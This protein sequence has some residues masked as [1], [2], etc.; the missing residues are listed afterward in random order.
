MAMTRRF[1]AGLGGAAVL[2]GVVTMTAVAADEAPR[3]RPGRRVERI[4]IAGGFGQL[5]VALEDVGADDVA[6]L[7]LAGERGARVT[8]V[9]EG[10]AAEKA[11]IKDDDV[12]LQFGGDEV[13]SAAQLARLVRETP[14]GRKV[15]VEVSRDG[16]SQ[17]L[18]VTLARP[19]H[20]VFAFGPGGF[21]P[22]EFHFRMPDIEMPDLPEIADMPHP[23]VPPVPPVPPAFED[24]R[25]NRMFFR[26]PGGG[27]RLG[28]SYQE[29]GDQLA[30]YFKVEGGV[31]VTD[32]EEDGPA[33]KAGVKAGDVIVSFGGK[34]VGDGDDLR[35]ALR[36]ASGSVTIGVRR[37]GR[38]M[39][40]T[41]TLAEPARRTGRPRPTT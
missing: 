9:H 16:A 7:K 13:R 14:A 30:R 21:G 28:L 6:R 10:S 1:G 36:E 20:D 32:V 23:P 37:E 38:A 11:G 19:D 4:R 25:G 2:L 27:R 8:D 12:I 35:E 15:E 24:G 39:D 26:G 17:R 40:L 18:T 31:L 5:G 3:E 33:A 22:G 34:A 41:V 29:L